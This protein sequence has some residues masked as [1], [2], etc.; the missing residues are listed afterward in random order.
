MAVS[1]RLRYETF[2][3]DNHTCRY[4]GR[5]A[6]DVK[7]TIDHVVPETLGGSDDPS[8]L[9]TACAD[10]NSGKSATPPDAPLVE[11]VRQ[12]ALRWAQAMTAAAL[13]REYERTGRD[14][15]REA[16][17]A[18]WSDWTYGADK[19]PVPRPGNWLDTIDAFYRY[20]LPIDEMREAVLV[21][22]RKDR[23]LPEGTFRYFCGVCWRVLDEMR[24]IAGA[25]LDK[26]EADRGQ[27]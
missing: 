15:Y 17:E 4:C 1:K 21:A 5:S 2:R 7:L 12:D 22:M 8:N 25:L 3:R 14:E 13:V 9:V 11:D 10:C 19:K 26:E 23:V 6:P 24:E 20:G 16:F 27:E 18:V